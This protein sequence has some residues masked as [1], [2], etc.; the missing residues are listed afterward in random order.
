MAKDILKLWKATDDLGKKYNGFWGDYNDCWELAEELRDGLYPRSNPSN[1]RF[2]YLPDYSHFLINT[3]KDY[4]KFARKNGIELRHRFSYFF[5]V[6]MHTGQY[7]AMYE[8]LMEEFSHNQLSRED[9]LRYI[10]N[11]GKITE[12][13]VMTSWILEDYL[14]ENLSEESFK[15]FNAKFREGY[16]FRYL[17]SANRLKLWKR[18]NQDTRQ[19]GEDKTLDF[20]FYKFIVD[21]CN[22]LERT[23]NIKKLTS[24]ELFD[25]NNLE[26][27]YENSLDEKGRPNM[28]RFFQNY[29][30][31]KSKEPQTKD[32]E[33]DDLNL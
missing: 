21:V 19:Y 7:L 15:Y 30:K 33:D 2:D 6:R 3:I 16:F 10:K 14:K 5:K 22:R 12:Y 24:T 9:V 25:L 27:W 20:D 1:Y 8:Y 23:D 32:A 18:T 29:K 13:C 31:E 11:N 17:R 28:E 26:R 4:N